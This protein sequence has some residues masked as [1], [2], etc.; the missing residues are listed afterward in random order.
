MKH[1]SITGRLVKDAREV[2]TEKNNFLSFSVAV[3]DPYNKDTIYFDCISNAL[4]LREYLKKG[5]LL[6]VNGDFGLRTYQERQYC[7]VRATN[8]T[9][10]SKI[11]NHKNDSI[12]NKSDYLNGPD[13]IPKDNASNHLDDEI[14]KD[15]VSNDLDDEIPF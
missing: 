15:G 9:L 5:T 11:N 2:T 3:N 12:N 7:T 4:K 13:E 1:I 14:P 8:I 10:L 6:G